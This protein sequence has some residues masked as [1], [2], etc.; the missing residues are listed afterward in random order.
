MAIRIFVA[1]IAKLFINDSGDQ[2]ALNDDGD[3]LE[4]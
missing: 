4:L 3:T 2:L 1:V